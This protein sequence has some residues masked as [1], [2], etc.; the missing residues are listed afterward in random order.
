MSELHSINMID[1]VQD[2][3]S[4]DTSPSPH[5]DS[6]EPCPGEDAS[7]VGGICFNIWDPSV[8]ASLT[9]RSNIKVQFKY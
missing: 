8:K 2:D 1:D 7:D 9:W 5:F 3:R 4:D 6:I